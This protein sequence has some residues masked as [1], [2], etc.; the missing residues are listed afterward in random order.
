LFGI[1]LPAQPVSNIAPKTPA[2][3]A[4]NHDFIKRIS[5]P[6]VLSDDVADEWLRGYIRNNGFI[7][8]KMHPAVLCDL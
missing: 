8:K 1:I 4:H 5:S 3:I 6:L 2:K 7:F